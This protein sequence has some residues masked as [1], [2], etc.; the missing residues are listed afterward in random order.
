L[1]IRPGLLAGLLGSLIPAAATAVAMASNHD[2]PVVLLGTAEDE[3]LTGRIAAE[4]RALGIGIEIRVVA[5]D[6]RGIEV[7]VE[8]DFAAK[9]PQCR[10]QRID[11]P[12]F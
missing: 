2:A 3:P 4:L 7:E 10:S 5:G 6:E 11:R 12:G 8:S 1:N 9:L